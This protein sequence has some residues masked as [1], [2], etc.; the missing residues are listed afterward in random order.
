MLL[1]IKHIRRNPVNE[2][3]QSS[4]E[5]GRPTFYSKKMKQTAVWLTE[6]MI[7]WLK[8]QPGTMSEVI[9]KLIQD[10]MDKNP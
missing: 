2:K 6:E 8:S 3:D 9:R 10:A 5:V 1:K 4:G 7:K